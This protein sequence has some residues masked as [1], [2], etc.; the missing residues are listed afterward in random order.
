MTINPRYCP[1]CPAS[2]WCITAS[3]RRIEG[4]LLC[5][6]WVQVFIGKT[7]RIKSEYFTPFRLESYFNNHIE[8]EYNLER[9]YWDYWKKGHTKGFPAKEIPIHDCFLTRYSSLFTRSGVCDE[10]AARI[11]A[12]FMPENVLGVFIEHDDVTEDGSFTITPVT[13]VRT[14]RGAGR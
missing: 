2:M 12:A 7:A 10:C 5:G 13:Q 1:P 3:E 11:D 14:K 6:A 8:Q 9:A 4:C